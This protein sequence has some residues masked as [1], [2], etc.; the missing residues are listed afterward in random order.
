MRSLP[1]E[2]LAR[3][4]GDA[5]PIFGGMVFLSILFF[6][7]RPSHFAEFRGAVSWCERMKEIVLQR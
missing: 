5:I 4:L 7:W 2:L 1:I 6:I 3:Q